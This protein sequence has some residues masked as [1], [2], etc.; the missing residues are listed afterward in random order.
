MKSSFS[1]VSSNFANALLA[2]LVQVAAVVVGTVLC[3]VG[4]LVGGPVAALVLTY[5]YRKL[6]GSQV[7]PLEQP[8]GGYHPG[9]PPGPPPGPQF[10]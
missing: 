2:W 9:P 3:G 6:S 5:S 4:L 1:T 7:V 8:G 10:G